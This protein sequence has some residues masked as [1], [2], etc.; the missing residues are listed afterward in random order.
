MTFFRPLLLIVTFQEMTIKHL[1][2]T[3]KVPFLYTERA[4]VLIFR[5]SDSRKRIFYVKRSVATISD[6]REYHSPLHPYLSRRERKIFFCQK[7]S[8][9]SSLI[10]RSISSSSLI[11]PKITQQPN[12]TTTQPQ[13]DNKT[14]Q[15]QGEHNNHTT[16]T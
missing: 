11:S 3:R 15:L 16:T 4:C 9:L 12:N 13:Q 2:Y 7:V 1:M 6:Q 5:F 8:S 10:A 14:T